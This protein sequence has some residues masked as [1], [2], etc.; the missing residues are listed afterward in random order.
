MDALHHAEPELPL[1]FVAQDCP[2]AVLPMSAAVGCWR[3][4]EEGRKDGDVL[5]QIFCHCRSMAGFWRTLI[6]SEVY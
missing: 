5:A 2:D 1:H 6:A 3:E 4:L